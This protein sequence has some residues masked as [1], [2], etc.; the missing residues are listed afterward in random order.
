M[1]KKNFFEDFQKKKEQIEILKMIISYMERN[2]E[3]LK[4]LKIKNN[5]N[6]SIKSKISRNYSKFS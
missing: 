5:K 1:N 3:K 4:L 6:E 2:L